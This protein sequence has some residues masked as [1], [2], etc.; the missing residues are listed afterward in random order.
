MQSKSLLAVVAVAAAC[1]SSSASAHSPLDKGRAGDLAQ[2]VEQSN[3]VFI[4]TAE[5]I[6]YRNAQGDKG[7]GVIPYTIVT[8]R[9]GQVLRGKAPGKEITM[10]LVG[11]PDGR[12]RFLSVSG[13]P[14]IQK[15]DQDLLF[16]ANTKDASCPLVFCEYGR[17]RILNEQVFD[18][19]G[20]PVRAILK[21]TVLS[22]GLPPKPFQ[23]VQFPT[24]RFDE[25]MKNPEVAEQ[26]KSQKISVEDARRRYE[27]G[28][29]KYLEFTEEFP[30]AEKGSDAG[31]EGPPTAGTGTGS[32]GPG[33]P[34]TQVETTPTV[35][36]G[37]LPLSEFVAVTK[38]LAAASKRK[39]AEVRSVDP[40][41]VIVAAKISLTVPKQLA[42][43]APPPMAPGSAEEYKAF[44]QNGYDP[45]IRK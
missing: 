5:K 30:A 20:S 32:S 43:P 16:V 7:E 17:F 10:R 14:V 22:R 42:A 24:P 39:P 3:L 36:A 21:S 38:R 37:P 2:L 29:P 18:T 33:A 8:Y 15:G 12:G 34:V 9:V 23:T 4:G 6:A 31:T 13:V 26:L 45:V 44:E 19:H 35:P 27:A 28:A 1:I 11:G 25:L 40:A 41:A